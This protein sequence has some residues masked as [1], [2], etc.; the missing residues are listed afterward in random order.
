MAIQKRLNTV[1]LRPIYCSLNFINIA[2]KDKANTH[3]SNMQSS[4]A[5]LPAFENLVTG[6][7]RINLVICDTALLDNNHLLL[8]L[9]LQTIC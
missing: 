4:R 8:L 6:Q 5:I 9:L 3:T 7:C 1:A 2:A